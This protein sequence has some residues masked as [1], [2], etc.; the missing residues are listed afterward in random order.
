MAF[1]DA[2]LLPGG[3]IGYTIWPNDPSDADGLLRNADK[4]L[5][6]AKANGRGSWKAFEPPQPLRATG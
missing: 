3:T 6:E 1:G 5:Y 2:A 4:A